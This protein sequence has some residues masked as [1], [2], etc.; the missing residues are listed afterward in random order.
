MFLLQG[1][2]DRLQNAWHFPIPAF[3]TDTFHLF[4]RRNT[5]VRLPNYLLER[6]VLPQLVMELEICAS[7]GMLLITSV[8]KFG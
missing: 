3:L 5:R 2:F 7:E 6:L 1:D 4:Q 8:P